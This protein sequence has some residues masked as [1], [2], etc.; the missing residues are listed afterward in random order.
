[1]HKQS[2]RLQVG[3]KSSSQG[4]ESDKESSGESSMEVLNI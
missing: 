2:K 1:M 4:G 3:D